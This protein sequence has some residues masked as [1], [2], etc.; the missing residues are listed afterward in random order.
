M[1][2]RSTMVDLISELRT[3]TD[4]GT[5]D[6]T[7]SSISYWTDEQLQSKLDEHRIAVRSVGMEHAA[8]YANGTY[9]YKEYAL[10]E[11]WME[12][13]T[14]LT[15][16]DA[17]GVTIA[18]TEYVFDRDRNII[19]FTADTGGAARFVS[20]NAYNLNMAAATIWTLKAAHVASKYDV[21]TDNHNL[22]RSQLIRQYKQMAQE[23]Y[24]K[25]TPGSVYMERT[26]T[27]GR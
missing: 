12:G 1:T 8:D 10:P 26:D 16:Q 3:M 20:G 24:D 6:Y 15:I 13:G 19:T 2:I 7:I 22:Q 5:T 17:D 25:G 9:T 27:Y 4:T 21:S 11:K 23:Y 14:A 18:P